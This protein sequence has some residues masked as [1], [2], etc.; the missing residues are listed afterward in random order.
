M[1]SFKIVIIWIKDIY[2]YIYII[3]VLYII[4][5]YYILSVD[6]L[7]IVFNKI[8]LFFQPS[9]RSRLY[10]PTRGSINPATVN[11]FEKASLDWRILTS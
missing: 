3:Y 6:V 8:H 2:I 1:V 5:I 9:W 10:I 11:T 4:Y 7:Y